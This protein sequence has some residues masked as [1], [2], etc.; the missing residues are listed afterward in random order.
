MSQ[1][2]FTVK[3][4][5]HSLFVMAGWDR[6]LQ[7]LF[8]L[9][10]KEPIASEA[11]EKEAPTVVL[12]DNGLRGMKDVAAIGSQLAS[13]GISVP[14]KLLEEVEK[15]RLGDVSMRVVTYEVAGADAQPVSPS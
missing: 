2:R 14:E 12:F 7:Q 4:A 15:D 13:L 11:A 9:V 3:H 10:E 8:L 5:D 1:H 6:P